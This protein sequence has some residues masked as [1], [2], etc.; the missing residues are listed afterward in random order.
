[1][2]LNYNII[3]PSDFDVFK[4]QLAYRP[5]RC[6]LERIVPEAAAAVPRRNDPALVTQHHVRIGQ[7]F[8]PF[9]VFAE[10]LFAKFHF[11]HTSAP[12]FVF[13][14]TGILIHILLYKKIRKKSR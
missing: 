2:D 11:F 4:I 13:R 6:T 9:T 8:C 5:V 10:F 12:P 14:S 3:C 1:M 7:R